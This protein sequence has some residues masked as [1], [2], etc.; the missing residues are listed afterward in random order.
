[1]A[2]LITVEVLII[3]LLKGGRMENIQNTDMEVDRVKPES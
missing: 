3:P 1:M 2:Q